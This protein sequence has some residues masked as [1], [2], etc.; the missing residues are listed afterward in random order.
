M[1]LCV[2]V[3]WFVSR[4][5]RKPVSTGTALAT[6]SPSDVATASTPPTGVRIEGEDA[7]VAHVRLKPNMAFKVDPA[8]LISVPQGVEVR[9]VY[10]A[11]QPQMERQQHYQ[12]QQQQQQQSSGVGG[13]LSRLR[14]APQQQPQPQPIEQEATAP[15]VAELVLQPGQSMPADSVQLGPSTAARLHTLNLNDFGGEMYVAAGS[16]LAAPSS[17]DIHTVPEPTGIPG[18]VLQRVD[19]V[20]SVVLKVA[21]QPIVRQLAQGEQMFAQANRIVAVE[22]TAQVLNGQGLLVNIV[23]PGRILLQSL[24][25]LEVALAQQAAATQQTLQNAG[26]QPPAGVQQQA[27]FAMGPMGMGMGGG[28]G[29]MVMQ[30]MAFGVGSSIAHHAIGSMFGG[31]SSQP[32]AAP[33]DSTP[34]ANDVQPPADGDMVDESGTS[35][36]ESDGSFFGGNFFG[37]DDS[38]GDGGDFDGG[39][40]GEW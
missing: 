29:S 36:G 39:D 9:A 20:G 27:G 26:I 14:S 11:P 15:I 1:F 34:P 23:G 37:G 2:C 16:F 22:S 25:S 28:L 31:S 12:Q 33:A 8:S 6:R 17:V 5:P 24:P 30:G 35:G 19:G 40:G 10:G 7:Q 32:A 38:G 13:F 18:L 21:G 4:F 3:C